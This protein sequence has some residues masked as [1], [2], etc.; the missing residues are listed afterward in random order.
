MIKVQAS[1]FAFNL[2]G[3]RILPGV[4][5]FLSDMIANLG[6]TFADMNGI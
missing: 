4:Y 3:V 6:K 5:F 2:I 1:S